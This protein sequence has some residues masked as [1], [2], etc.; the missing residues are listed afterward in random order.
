MIQIFKADDLSG[1][2]IF[3]FDVATQSDQTEPFVWTEFPV[4]DAAFIAEHGF[5]KPTTWSVTGLITATPFDPFAP[6]ID[7]IRLTD[8]YQALRNLARERQVVRLVDR[9]EVN[10]C[11]ISNVSR[12]HN[13]D[14]GEAYEIKID[15]QS[16]ERPQLG[17]AQIP[18][19]R[20]KRRVKR[21]AS[22]V[23]K[24]GA[25]SGAAPSPKTVKAS[26]LAL[27]LAKVAGI[28]L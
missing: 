15:F 17:S 27:K 22:P 4:D 5:A 11:V 9:N 20:L 10:D 19:A 16:V 3:Q 21:R 7:L 28:K 2:P 6:S 24:G 25:K 26:T 23:K 18:P 13:R 14:Q 1:L 12:S 8:M